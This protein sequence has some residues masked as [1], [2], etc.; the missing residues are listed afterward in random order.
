MT[1]QPG[2]RF[3]TANLSQSKCSFRDCINCGVR[4]FAYRHPTITSAIHLCEKHLDAHG[5]GLQYDIDT[6]SCK[7][8]YMISDYLLFQ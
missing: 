5:D 4:T 8:L 6:N 2:T 1:Y 7:Y 3:H